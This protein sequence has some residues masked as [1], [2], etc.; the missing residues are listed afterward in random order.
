MRSMWLMR[1]MMGICISALLGL[2]STA[3]PAAAWQSGDLDQTTQGEPAQAHAE[4]LT[5]IS[6]DFLAPVVEATEVDDLGVDV[7]EEKELQSILA[8]KDRPG[9]EVPS[10][11]LEPVP[12]PELH[13]D[14]PVLNGPGV[15]RQDQPT[16]VDPMAAFDGAETS[17]T[18]P[19]PRRDI[20]AAK[21]NNIQPGTTTVS[22]LKRLWGEPVETIENETSQTLI[23]HVPSFRQV[24]VTVEGD[25]VLSVLVHLAGSLKASHVAR[26]LNLSRGGACTR[27]FRARNEL[28]RLLE[29]REGVE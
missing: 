12:M 15:A 24:D 26:E 1:S 21:F 17:L 11:Q 22:E 23:Y 8:N 27:L 16:D 9:D 2:G 18:P 10:P 3:K 28:R 19:N 6:A 20:R 29:E 13:E 7:T 25:E 14:T 5:P 4:E